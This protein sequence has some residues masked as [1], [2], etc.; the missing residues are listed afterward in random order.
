M[1]LKSDA[2]FEEKLACCFA[3]MTGVWQI[4]TK[5]LESLKIRTL[6]GYFNSKQKKDELK[7]YREVIC[8]DNEE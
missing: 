7:I 6:M 8:H 1:I 3:K 2:K 4:F 5:A